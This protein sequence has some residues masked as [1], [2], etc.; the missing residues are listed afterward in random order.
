MRTVNQTSAFSVKSIFFAQLLG[1]CQIILAIFCLHHLLIW[2][3]FLIVGSMYSSMEY[4]MKISENYSA[5]QETKMKKRLQSWHQK[6][7]MRLSY[8]LAFHPNEHTGWAICIWTI[9]EIV[10]GIQ[11]S[12]ATPTKFSMLFNHNYDKLSWKF[13]DHSLNFSFVHGPSW[14][15]ILESIHRYGVILTFCKKISKGHCEAMPDVK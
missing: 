4:M 14:L 2:W 12:Q 8:L 6:Q 1:F 9:F 5:A 11:M 15:R 7:M 13:G 10:C 3:Q